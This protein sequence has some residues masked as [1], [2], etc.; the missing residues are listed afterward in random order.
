[1]AVCEI[2]GKEKN[3]RTLSRAIICEE[4]FSDL[5]KIRDGNAEVIDRYLLPST[6][7]QAS[8]RGKEY[9]LETIAEKEKNIEKL[10]KAKERAVEN[11]KKDEEL[12]KSEA[13]RIKNFIMTTTPNI[14]G[15]EIIKYLGIVSGEYSMGTGLFAELDAGISDF[16][17][18]SAGAYS[19]K[20]G[21]AKIKATNI[22]AQ[23]ALK[24]GA[25]AVVGIDID[26]MTTNANIFIVCA[27][28]TAVIKKPIK[29]PVEEAKKDFN[30]Q[31]S[32]LITNYCVEIP[33][34]FGRADIYAKKDAYEIE[35][36][37]KILGDL[38]VDAINVDIK[39]VTVFD[40]V[41]SYDGCH[42]VVLKDDNGFKTSK[43]EISLE[44]NDFSIIKSA[45][46]F[47]KTYVSQKDAY[48]IPDTCEYTDVDEDIVSLEKRE[49]NGYEYCSE[50][51]KVENGWICLCGKLNAYDEEQCPLCGRKYTLLEKTLS[52]YY[53]LYVQAQELSS[54]KEIYELYKDFYDNNPDNNVGVSLSALESQI[55]IER[56]YGNRKAKALAII[57]SAQPDD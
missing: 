27:N 48:V 15:Y 53:K 41:I 45:K 29:S 42:F 5:Q 12:R 8:A 57:E 14:E 52:D 55:E 23:N 9:F 4:C 19:S 22:M 32:L 44:Q 49:S 7:A 21:K 24:M 36:K 20:L 43:L 3:C 25:N 13:S 6:L 33:I 17:G 39:L 34:R 35:L 37:G 38:H 31:K 1:M 56:M 46:V 50:F 47:L 40:E 26:I 10:D 18:G 51:E 11:A 2:C 28:G 16:L 54:A 30:T